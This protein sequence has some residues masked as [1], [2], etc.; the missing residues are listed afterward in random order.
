VY[1]KKLVKRND[2]A[3][4]A[5]VVLYGYMLDVKT[6]VRKITINLLKPNNQT[7]FAQTAQHNVIYA[8]SK[9]NQT[10]LQYS[11]T[12]VTTGYII[13]AQVLSPRNTKNCKLLQQLG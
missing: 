13:S 2:K 8:I 4:N 7:G 10:I 6:L 12:T 1:V 5:M 3:Y 9:S 11:A